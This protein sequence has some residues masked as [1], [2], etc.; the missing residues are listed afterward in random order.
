MCTSSSYYFF[1]LG[2]HYHSFASICNKQGGGKAQEAAYIYDELIEKYGASPV[3]LN[4][5]AVS[6]MHLSQWEEAETSLKEA[7]TKVCRW[8]CEVVLCMIVSFACFMQDLQI[9]LFVSFFNT[10][11]SLF[12][13]SQRNAV[14]V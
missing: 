9:T 1:T 3:L 13:P 11:F 10:D 2:R 14:P 5:L 6:K 4:G 12:L 7:I 8:L